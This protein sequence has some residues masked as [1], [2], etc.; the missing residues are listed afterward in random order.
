MKDQA[1]LKEY[2]ISDG[3]KVNS[4]V[5]LKFRQILTTLISVD[6]DENGKTGPEKT[7]RRSLLVLFRRHHRDSAF[8][9]LHRQ[10][11]EETELGL[12]ARRSRA[13]RAAPVRSPANQRPIKVCEDAIFFYFLLP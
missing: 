4:K 9:H 10:H 11:E 12:F 5:S 7:P 2:K 3:A 6:A 8:R 1:Q 13:P